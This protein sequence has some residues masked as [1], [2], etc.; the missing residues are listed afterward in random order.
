MT[1]LAMLLEERKRRTRHEHWRHW[2]DRGLSSAKTVAMI[3]FGF[4]CY[5]FRDQIQ[6]V[7]LNFL[8]R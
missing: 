1:V 2:V 7:L 4:W 8:S 5:T 6:A 3:A